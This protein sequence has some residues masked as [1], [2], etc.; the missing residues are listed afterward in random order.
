[1]AILTF[2]P[3]SLEIENLQNHFFLEFI[4]FL[5]EISSVKIKY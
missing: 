5:G 4:Y 2:F 3:L 1:M